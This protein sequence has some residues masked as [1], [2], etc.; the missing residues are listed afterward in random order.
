MD[1]EDENVVDG[2]DKNL[3]NTLS[4]A[5][6]KEKLTDNITHLDLSSNHISTDAANLLSNHLKKPDSKLQ[7]LALVHCHLSTRSSKIIFEA[8]GASKLIEFYADNNILVQEACE[9]LGDALKHGPPL[10]VLSLCGCQ[11]PSEGGIAIANALPSLTH[12]IHLRLE[13]NSLFDFGAQAIAKVMKDC[14]FQYLNL[15]DNEIWLEGTNELLEAITTTN[16]LKSLD[17]SYNILDLDNLTNCVLK[18]T[19]LTELAISGAKIPILQLITFLEKIINSKLE[20]LIMDGFDTNQLPVAWP[21][22]HDT[23]FKQ[24]EYFKLLQNLLVNS[25]TLRDVRIGYLEP[26]QIGELSDSL[27]SIDHEISLSLHD[28]GRTGNCWVFTYPETHILAPTDVFKWQEQITTPAAARQIG[29]FFTT[30][31]FNENPMKT[32]DVSGCQISDSCMVQMLMGI[33]HMEIDIFDMSNNNFGDEVIDQL[34]AMVSSCKIRDFRCEKT[35]ITEFGLERFLTFI[36]NDVPDNCPRELSFTVISEDKN[37]FSVHGVFQQ[38]AEVI[39]QGCEL[40][41]ICIDGAITTYDVKT[42]V[43]ELAANN[44]IIHELSIETEMMK[45]YSSPDPPIDENITNGFLEVCTSLHHLICEVE[46][47]PLR[48]FKWPL[49]TEIFMYCDMNMMKM[50]YEIE[51]KLEENYNKFNESK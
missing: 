16:R 19:N 39:R 17:L 29:Q 33:R 26:D 15:S 34:I 41:S 32:L 35:K 4:L 40:E 31:K 36:A 38:L 18:N 47:C 23:I 11:I 1:M 25:K 6:V 37:P 9:V 3:W 51:A 21:K 8:V 5:F 7:G 22:I 24:T 20:V 30:A 48:D 13:S 27:S 28:F 10:E 50:R 44:P 43:D 2:S 14:T 12:L 42:F 45:D 49:L 46:N